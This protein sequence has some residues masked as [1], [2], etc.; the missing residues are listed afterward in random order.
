MLKGDLNKNSYP[1]Y[2]NNTKK[3]KGPLT[4]GAIQRLTLKT[5]QEQK[6]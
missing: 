1:F 2:T 6:N 4:R 3:N 5:A